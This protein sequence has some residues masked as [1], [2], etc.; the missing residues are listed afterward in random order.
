MYQK[1]LHFRNAGLK[2][3]G[4]AQA[5]GPLKEET[6][7]RPAKIIPAGV[8][9]GCQHNGGSQSELKSA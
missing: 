8:N 5:P 4:P 7:E 2:L 6:F 9:S 3:S 1:D